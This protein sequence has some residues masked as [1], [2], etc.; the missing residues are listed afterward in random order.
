MDG[1]L[2]GVLSHLHGHHT[3]TGGPD[4]PVAG[5]GRLE[6]RL[7]SDLGL[8]LSGWVLTA[9]AGCK[10]RSRGKL[11]ANYV[12]DANGLQLSWLD[13]ALVSDWLW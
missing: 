4:R 8:H 2:H 12:G 3:C 6:S 7:A 11:E 10:C 5:N 1:E 9:G 13:H